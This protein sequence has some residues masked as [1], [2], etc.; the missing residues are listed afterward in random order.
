MV[1]PFI[2]PL[3]ASGGTLFVFSSS[4]EDLGT[5]FSN[6]TAKFRFSKF[7]LLN[8]PHIATPAFAENK[9]QFEAIDGA[10]LAGLNADQNINFA[11][12]LQNYCFNLESGLISQSTYDQSLKLNVSERVF[13]KWLKEVGGIRFNA[14][15]SLQ[16]NT[17]IITDPRFVEETEVLT[18]PNRYNRVVQ[19]VGDI[20]IVN[21][22]QNN[23]NAYSEVYI[24]IPTSDGNTPLVLF[25]TVSDVNYSESMIIQNRPTDPL[26]TDY[27]FGRHYFDVHPAN[28][29]TI[30]FFDQ[31][32]IGSPVSMFYDITNSSYD[33][34][35]NWFDPLVGPHAYFTD[36]LFTD[37]TT[38]KIQKTYG[39][40]TITYQRSRLDGIQLDFD[41]TNYKPITD[42]PALT[43]IQQYNSTVDA[44]QFEFNAIL[45][46]YDVF[47]PNDPT[48]FQTNLY[49][50]LFL[51]DVEQISTEYGIPTF[52]KYKPN[53]ITKLNGNSYGFKI[54]VKFDTS[55]DNVGITE[56][57]INDYSTFSLEMFVDAMNVVQKTSS[58]LTQQTQE[59]I[60]LNVKL[61]ELEDLILNSGNVQEI[62]LRL[63]ALEDNFIA[64]QAIFNN[65]SDL[66]SLITKVSDS[67][68]NL[69][70]GQTSIE[71]AYNSNVVKNG[72]GIFIDRSVP[73]QITVDNIV[74]SYNI[75]TLY[76][77]D[78]SLGATI[79]LLMYNNYFRHSVSGAILSAT[80]DIYIKIDDSLIKWKK[81][82]SFKIVF[83]DV[84]D[85]QTNS[86]IIQTDATNT[87]GNGTYGILIGTL[88][89]TDF[90]PSG[91]KPIIEIICVDD[92]NMIF[93]IDRLR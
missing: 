86:I 63:S 20:S 41:P 44:Q 43:T 24:H 53:V 82:Q 42:N 14:A 23:V 74:Q 65:T 39:L 81:G 64:N 49:G 59:M 34:P 26:D 32:A 60:D 73:N 6:S 36:A 40:S 4:S 75:G 1:A 57:A 71:V 62:Y 70:A 72:D 8:I 87:F 37:A 15:N 51:N 21:S 25:K 45:V 92:V 5:T 77:G 68:A 48:N 19:Y 84:L 67:L 2:R 22:V 7:A 13:W 89:E 46:Y 61:L 35:E 78:L 47:D 29:R 54:N 90:S 66:M 80:S 31:D 9:I 85:M 83:D 79:P 12:S 69:L 28:L 38:D 52:Q 18:G 10:L 55:V 33:I 11:E 88:N 17:N 91:D 3:N 93:V 27:L 16:T 76:Y 50:V 56:K 58:I 30:A